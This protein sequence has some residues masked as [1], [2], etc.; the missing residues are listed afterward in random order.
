MRRSTWVLFE[1]DDR[2]SQENI[3]I[4][5][6]REWGANAEAGEFQGCWGNYKK[7][8]IYRTW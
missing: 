4:A 5:F 3:R 6:Q 2:A 8:I 1:R 7:T